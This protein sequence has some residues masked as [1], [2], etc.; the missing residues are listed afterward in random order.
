[1]AEVVGRNAGDMRQLEALVWGMSPGAV[2][3]ALGVTEVQLAEIREGRMALAPGMMEEMGR[4]SG[5]VG[6]AVGWLEIDPA[7]VGDGMLEGMVGVD[8]DGDGEMDVVFPVVG[9]VSTGEGWDEWMERKRVSLWTSRSL[10][11]MTQFRMG[12]RHDEQVAALELVTRIELALISAF[13]E[14]VPEPGMRWDGEKRDR[15]IQKRLARLRW[16]AREQEREYG[17][18]K[19]FLNRMIGRERLS[20]KE[21]YQRMMEGADEML[22]EMAGADRGDRGEHVMR[23]VMKYTGALDMDGGRG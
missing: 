22:S 7:P 11:L 20:G 17:G 19:G 4:M 3:E 15:E 2:A 6:D 5:S 10:A 8:V 9:A 18:L 23:E 13:K 12:M 1:M 16:V 21:L 14:S